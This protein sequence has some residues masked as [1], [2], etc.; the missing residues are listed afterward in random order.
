MFTLGLTRDQAVETLARVQS[1]MAEL[2]N[3][4]EALRLPSES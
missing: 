4:S 2:D 3:L 1:S